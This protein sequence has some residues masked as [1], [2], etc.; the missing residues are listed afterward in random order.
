MVSADRGIGAAVRK[1][2]VFN[3]VI[4][5]VVAVR[6]SDELKNSVKTTPFIAAFPQSLLAR[7]NPREILKFAYGDQ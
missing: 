2:A 6:R 4:H 5:H 7:E 3:D 1:G